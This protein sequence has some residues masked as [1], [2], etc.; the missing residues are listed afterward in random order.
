MTA[1]FDPVVRRYFRGKKV[2][3]TGGSSGIGEALA[4]AMIALDAEVA[5]VAHRPEKLGR[6]VTEAKARVFVCDL[7]DAAQTARLAEQML[8]EFGTPDVL[9]NNAGFAT[10]RPFEQIPADE[11]EALLSVNLLAALRLTRALLPGFIARR[12]G[13]IVNMASIAGRLPLTP[14][15]AYTAAKHGMV[16]WS[17]CLSYELARFGIQ[18]NVICPGRVETAFFDHETFRTRAERPETRYTVPLER[19]VAGTLAA[20]AR[21]RVVTYIP[22][23]LALFAWAKSAF[24]FIVGPFYRRLVLGRV[25]TLYQ[26][27]NR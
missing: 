14:N 3:V 6:A 13:A 7:S 2:L 22:W 19:V 25:E 15:M 26:S 21:G 8:A 16:A 17:E 10:Y 9:V 23:T 27:Q 4:L 24:P 20:I 11:M 5:V 12:S 18:V 1:V